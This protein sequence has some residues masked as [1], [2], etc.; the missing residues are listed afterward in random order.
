MLL[1]HWN[2][3][4]ENQLWLEHPII[5][6]WPPRQHRMGNPSLTQF[7]KLALCT[8]VKWGGRCTLLLFVSPWIS[9]LSMLLCC[10]F[11]SLLALEL[12]Y[13]GHSASKKLPFFLLLSGGLI[14]GPGA[15]I[16]IKLPRRYAW[17]WRGCTMLR[18]L[19]SISNKGTRI[20][21]PARRSSLKNGPA[22]LVSIW[23]NGKTIRTANHL[24]ISFKESNIIKRQIVKE[25]NK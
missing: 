9:V 5:V 3:E 12:A 20:L 11:T 14:S 15:S 18:Y 4:M 2:W 23:R 21:G 25:N 1:S 16:I 6:C 24:R 8:F 22:G 13:L 19:D 17:I 10:F 7:S